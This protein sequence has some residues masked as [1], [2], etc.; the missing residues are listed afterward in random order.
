LSAAAN[1]HPKV[2]GVDRI[3]RPQAFMR[4]RGPVLPGAV[5]ANPTG[6]KEDWVSAASTDA[7]GRAENSVAEDALV[8]LRRAGLIRS[9]EMNGASFVVVVGRGTVSVAAIDAPGVLHLASVLRRDKV[10]VVGR[11]YPVMY[12]TTRYD[13]SDGRF[14]DRHDGRV[15]RYLDLT[16]QLRG[17]V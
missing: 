14:A 8:A 2:R 11:G 5:G 9:W 15:G 3:T 13:L 17:C 16:D 7:D 6:R 1:R 4:G 12:R 10:T